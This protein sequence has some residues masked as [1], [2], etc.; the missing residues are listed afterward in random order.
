MLETPFAATLTLLVGAASPV[1][2]GAQDAQELAGPRVELAAGLELDVTQSTR[3]IS[4]LSLFRTL[5]GSE[6]VAEMNADSAQPSIDER[7]VRFRDVFVSWPA[8]DAGGRVVRRSFQELAQKIQAGGVQDR[9]GLL[10][11]RTLVL[12]A[13]AS[14]DEGPRVELVAPTQEEGAQGQAA[15]AALP[16]DALEGHRLPYPALALLPAGAVEP[17]AS[18]EVSS[19]T[20][21]EL[22]GLLEGARYFGPPAE[23][24][25]AFED[26]LR[27]GARC[28][29]RV[30]YEGIEPFPPGE[31]GERC[32]V[33]SYELTLEA[34][35]ER[36]DPAVMG[37]PMPAG[38]TG[39]AMR[40]E[41]HG[42][43]RL[44]IACERAL[45]VARSLTLEAELAL[46]YA[47][48]ALRTEVELYVRHGLEERWRAP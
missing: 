1:L 5:Q 7:R 26:A 36:F 22:L 11:G 14:T 47:R 8:G 33:L 19:H 20:A 30:R 15:D 35:V 46:G 3:S 45:P 34:D 24:A 38:A 10:T 17:G 23:G 29:G 39:G 31:G 48:G 37:V 32:W 13:G 27:S 4:G 42:E 28:G 40:T 6:V 9:Q 16:D 21:L 2:A 44:W 25:E 12:T 18:W 43:G 41:A